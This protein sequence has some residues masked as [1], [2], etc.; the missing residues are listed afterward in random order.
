MKLPPAQLRRLHPFICGINS[1][2]MN[3]V[4]HVERM[5]KAYPGLWQGIGEVF[6]RHDDL[7]ALTYD[8]V[9]RADMRSFDRLADL[10]EKYDMPMLIHSNI[11]PAWTEQPNYLN[12][13]EY[14]VRAHPK[15]KII[16]AHAGISRRIVIPNHTEILAR[17]LNQYPNLRVDISWVIFEQEIAPNNLLDKRWPELIEQFPDRFI[18]GSDVVGTFSQYKPTIQRYYLLLDALDPATARKVAK[19]NFLSLLP[20]RRVTSVN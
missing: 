19:E 10:A 2:D 5:I 17:L 3:A 7:S 14:L 8:G 20:P 18:I 15:A 12:E 9:S 6:A 4:D 1:S 13:I 11:G 16:W